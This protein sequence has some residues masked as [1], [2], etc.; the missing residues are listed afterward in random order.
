MLVKTIIKREFGSHIRNF[1][2]SSY[3]TI[4]SFKKNRNIGQLNAIYRQIRSHINPLNYVNDTMK[5]VH[6][7]Y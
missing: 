2:R 6:P 7:I 4:R 5:S 1:P 3:Y